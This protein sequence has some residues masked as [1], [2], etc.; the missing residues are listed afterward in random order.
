MKKETSRFTAVGGKHLGKVPPTKKQ[1]EDA[2]KI[3]EH[4]RSLTYED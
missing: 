2:K 4:L 3:A 1:K